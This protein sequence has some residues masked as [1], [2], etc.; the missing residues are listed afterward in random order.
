MSGSPTGRVNGTND[1]DLAFLD[2]GVYL[3]KRCMRIIHTIQVHIHMRRISLRV[4]R[5]S[6]SAVPDR[7]V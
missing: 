3:Q 6:A 5:R 7:N 2:F 1:N 4:L